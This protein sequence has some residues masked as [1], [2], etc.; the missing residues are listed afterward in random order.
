MWKLFYQNAY[1]YYLEIA[2]HLDK[3]L[4]SKYLPLE[5]DNN[6]IELVTKQLIDKYQTVYQTMYQENQRL[7]KENHTLLLILNNKANK[8]IINSQECICIGGENCDYCD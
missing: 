3:F 7:V 4:D 1:N 8:K 6:E 5:D 2:K